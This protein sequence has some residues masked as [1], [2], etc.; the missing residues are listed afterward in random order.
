MHQGAM[1]LGVDAWQAPNGFNIIG[2]VIYR[3]KEN[4]SGTPKL[5]AMP[6]SFVQLKGSHTGKYLARMV[7]YIVE[8]FGLQ[9][10]T[11]HQTTLQWSPNWRNSGGN[12]SKN[13]RETINLNNLC[14]DYLEAGKMYQDF[15]TGSINF[16]IC[17][18]PGYAETIRLR[19]HEPNKGVEG[20]P[21]IGACDTDEPDL[22]VG[23]SQL[24]QDNPCQL[25]SDLLQDPT[26]N[27]TSGAKPTL[28]IPQKK[29]GQLNRAINAVVPGGVLRAWPGTNTQS[30]LSKLG[31][32]LQVRKNSLGV[33]SLN[34]YVKTGNLKDKP[35]QLFVEALEEDLF[36]LVALP[37]PPLTRISDVRFQMEKILRVSV[38]YSAGSPTI[39]STQPANKFNISSEKRKRSDNKINQSDLGEDHRLRHNATTNSQPVV[40]LST[41]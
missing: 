17:K 32:S 40:N 37:V 23:G 22:L 12:V 26:V 14:R 28:A 19:P 29:K 11:T 6:L 15:L 24:N 4:K 25:F 8:K 20:F 10:R 33:T 9:N 31:V 30:K 35:A 5:N 36:G 16:N 34:F 38:G 18:D 39:T 3:L 13:S 41:S 7:Q 2:A 1:Y 27:E 21:V